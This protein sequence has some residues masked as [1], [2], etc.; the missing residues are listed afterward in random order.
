MNDF[1]GRFGRIHVS[2]G[3]IETEGRVGAAVTRSGR[4]GRG[5]G[6]RRG[7]GGHV[8]VCG[9]DGGGGGGVHAEQ[10]VR[11]QGGHFGR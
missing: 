10:D 8:D 11:V 7:G 3:R 1:R 9:R 2:D 5:R 4:G 6:H